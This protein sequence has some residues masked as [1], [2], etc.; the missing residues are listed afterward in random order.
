MC[1]RPIKDQEFGMKS[2][3]A[4]SCASFG[5]FKMVRFDAMIF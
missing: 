1:S 5:A 4:C 2:N 3:N